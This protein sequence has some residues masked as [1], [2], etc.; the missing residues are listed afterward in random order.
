MYMDIP[1]GDAGNPPSQTEGTTLEAESILLE[2]YRHNNVLMYQH[3]DSINSLFNLYLALGGVVTSAIA[4]A[5]YAYDQNNSKNQAVLLAIIGLLIGF[6]VLSFAFYSIFQNLRV[7]YQ[8]AIAAMEQITT[9]YL[10]HFKQKFP[11]LSEAFYWHRNP[12]RHGLGGDSRVMN[13]TTQIVGS[14]SLGQAGWVALILILDHLLGSSDALTRPEENI[15]KV[16]TSAVLF[17]LALFLYRALYR[18]P[19]RSS[20]LTGLQEAWQSQGS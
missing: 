11:K 2:E 4:V 3:R 6:S 14:Y 9:F 7:A 10:D 1:F 15:V 5:A 12:Q 18:G 13:W 20:K 19:A 17:L 16:G 8:D